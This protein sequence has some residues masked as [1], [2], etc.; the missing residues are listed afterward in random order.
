MK[1]LKKE[2]QKIR[3]LET[4]MSSYGTKH[5]L[6]SYEDANAE[7]RKVID[8]ME[9]RLYNLEDKAYANS[10]AKAAKAIIKKYGEKEYNYI[11]AVDDNRVR[12]TVALVF[13]VPILALAGLS[14]LIN[15]R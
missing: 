7:Q 4:K 5:K 8:R 12:G 14:A 13:G 9:T 6:N 1:I 2:E 10:K 11:K 15:S 3:D